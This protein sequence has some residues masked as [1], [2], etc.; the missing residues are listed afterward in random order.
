[1][2]KVWPCPREGGF[3]GGGEGKGVVGW[4]QGGGWSPPHMPS[5]PLEWCEGKGTTMCVSGGGSHTTKPHHSPPHQGKG[6][7]GVTCG[8]GCH[9]GA[10]ECLQGQGEG[11]CGV[12]V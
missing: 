4:C 6:G 9:V 3:K 8:W 12:V 2:V 5:P 7:L 1:M 11:T 10:C